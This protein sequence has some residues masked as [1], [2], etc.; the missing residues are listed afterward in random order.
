[1]INKVKWGTLIKALSNNNF[2]S[3]GWNLIPVTTKTFWCKITK[4][5]L[6]GMIEKKAECVIV[7][8]LTADHEKI[9]I[10]LSRKKQRKQK[11]IIT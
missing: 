3:S 6:L 8:L 10:V 4:D 5:F 11:T 9:M 1:M 2:D 7:E